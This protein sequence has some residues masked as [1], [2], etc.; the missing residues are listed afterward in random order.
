[1]IRAVHRFVAA[2]AAGIALGCGA[3]PHRAGSPNI[4]LLL[5]DD[6]GYG[7]LGSYGSPDIRTPNL[8]RLAR[9]GAR[10]TDAYAASPVCSPTRAALL[11]GLY[12]QWLGS[13]FE[14][15]LR[16]GGLDPARYTTLAEHLRRAGYATA[17]FGK[18]NLEGEVEP[19]RSTF[20][21]NQHG[22]EHW[23]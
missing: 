2:L 9:S 18:W 19:G 16:A 10:F 4:V 3:S 14:D 22:F 13:Q 20:L 12:P 21:P 15:Y 7:D 5:A 17:C 23:F 8:D 6:L 1:T 11:P